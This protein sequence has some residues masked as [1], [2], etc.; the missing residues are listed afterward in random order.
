M[1]AKFRALLADARTIASP[2]VRSSAPR[3]ARGASRATGV[4]PFELRELLWL[5][6][7]EARGLF[8]VL[9]KQK[10]ARREIPRTD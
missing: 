4:A 5:A 3:A 10:S 8:V 9:P 2:R 7:I 6:L 1:L